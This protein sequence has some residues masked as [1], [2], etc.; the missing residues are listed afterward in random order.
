MI[1]ALWLLALGIALLVLVTLLPR[2]IKVVRPL[3]L[4]DVLPADD[5]LA[6]ADCETL[7]EEDRR[8]VRRA[9]FVALAAHPHDAQQ[10]RELARRF[11]QQPAPEARAG[12]I[13]AATDAW[14]HASVA[15]RPPV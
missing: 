8:A 9:L 12:L 15:T 13:A 14:R 10:L 7:P 3:L 2:A 1:P 11:A 4:P 6:L 5:L